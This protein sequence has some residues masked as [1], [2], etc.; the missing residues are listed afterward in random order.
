MART[1][2]H[3][4]PARQTEQVRSSQF[5]VRRR[6]SRFAVRSSQFAVRGSR[7]AVRGSPFTVVVGGIEPGCLEVVGV[8]R[9]RDE[10]HEEFGVNSAYLPRSVR[11]FG[12]VRRWPK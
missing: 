11:Q 1:V 9:R 4:S 10:F 12:T 3:G 2:F 7:F 6:S 5:A 8:Y